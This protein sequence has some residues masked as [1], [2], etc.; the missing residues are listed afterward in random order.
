MDLKQH[1]GLRVKAARLKH[2]LTQE[3][4]GERIE[5]TA[6]SISN[7]ERGRVAPPLETLH[8][9]AIQLDT[10]LT[11]FVEGVTDERQVTQSRLEIENELR[12]LGEELTDDEMR[13][14]VAIVGAIRAQRRAGR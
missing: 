13:L 10:P 12:R 1:I 8:N 14:T 5:K 2:D 9:I 7:I 11:Y 3:Q 4:L 6:E